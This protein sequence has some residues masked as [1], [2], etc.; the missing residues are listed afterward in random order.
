MESITMSGNIHINTESMISY[1][2]FIVGLML[3]IILLHMIETIIE[4]FANNWENK[5]T[6][7][8]DTK[9]PSLSELRQIRHSIFY[10]TQPNPVKQAI[11]L[12][13][14]SYQSKMTVM[15]S[16]MT[17]QQLYS[18]KNILWAR[19]LSLQDIETVLKLENDIDVE[20]EIFPFL[21][22]AN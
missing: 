12:K 2:L 22:P 11:A 19:G 3:I 5:Y 6:E 14:K 10:Y 15:D 1:M 18:T 13:I 21:D 17:P 9:N 7:I 16:M 4:H 20:T 8:L